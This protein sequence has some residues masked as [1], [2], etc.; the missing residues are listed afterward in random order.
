MLEE[1]P[2]QAVIFLIASIGICT[3]SVVPLVRM[4]SWPP[5]PVWRCCPH[6]QTNK[7]A[8]NVLNYRRAPL[9]RRCG[10]Q[11]AAPL[12]LYQMACALLQSSVDQTALA[13]LVQNGGGGRPLVKLRAGGG[14]LPR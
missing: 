5:T 7:P 6:G 2:D 9:V 13:N 10:L 11:I 12:D 8:R 4:T 14:I 3:R 1:P